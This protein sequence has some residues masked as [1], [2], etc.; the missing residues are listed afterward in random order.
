[1]ANEETKAKHSAWLSVDGWAV[2]L[3]FALAVLVR[4]GVVQHVPW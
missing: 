2:L 3:A 4:F 1:M